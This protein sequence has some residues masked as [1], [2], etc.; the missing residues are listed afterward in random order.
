MVKRMNKDKRLAFTLA[1]VL[2]TLGIIG[3]VAAMT[4]PTLMNN[5]KNAEIVTLFKKEYSVLNNAWHQLI[6]ENGGSILEAYA[7]SDDVLDALCAELKCVKTC[8]AADSSECFVDTNWTKLDK[9]AS[10]QSLAGASAI[11]ADGVSFSIHNWNTGGGQLYMDI[12]NLKK[13][14][15]MGRDIF[16]FEMNKN[17]ISPE[18]TA[19]TANYQYLDSWCGGGSGGYQGATCGGKILIENAMNY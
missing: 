9:T 2:I 4:I 12:N 15:V 8:K 3:V 6:N 16:E 5:T 19:E 7:T 14:N 18:G 13:P 11:L 1:E 17:N 10:W